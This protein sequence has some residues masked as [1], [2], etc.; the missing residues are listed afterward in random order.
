M[1]C[2]HVHPVLVL[3][4]MAVDVDDDTGRLGTQ[5]GGKAIGIALLNGVVV[6]ARGD[7]ILVE[8]SNHY[9]WHKA[10]PDPQILMP[11]VHRIGSTLPVVKVAYDGDRT[12][13]GSPESEVDPH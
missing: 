8:R 5:F 3:P 1:L 2:T 12:R 4:L 10:F 13:I 11:Q 9:A 6:E 7:G